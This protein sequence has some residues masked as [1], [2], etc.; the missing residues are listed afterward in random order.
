M[1]SKV[2]A[3]LNWISRYSTQDKAKIFLVRIH[4][5][6]IASM[7]CECLRIWA[8]TVLP[9]SNCIIISL[10]ITGIDINTVKWYL[11]TVTIQVTFPCWL[12]N[13]IATYTGVFCFSQLQY[14][15]CQWLEINDP[16]WIHLAISVVTYLTVSI[17]KTV[18][19]G[20]EYSCTYAWN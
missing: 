8:S 13:I 18:A 9:N 3:L 10:T 16:K 2:V 5:P 12:I 20:W 15:T 1:H 4:Q 14:L 17:F 6:I 7:N 11:A 19:K